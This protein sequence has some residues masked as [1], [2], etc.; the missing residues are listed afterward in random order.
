MIERE[1]YVYVACSGQNDVDRDNIGEVEYYSSHFSHQIGGINFK[2]FPYMNQDNYISPLVFVHFKK[3]SMNILINVVCKAY[4]GNID[5][6]DNLNQRGM[7]KFNIFVDDR[8]K[9]EDL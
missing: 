9:S 4:A 2:Y 8:N 5:N 7:V 1:T 6:A 3:V